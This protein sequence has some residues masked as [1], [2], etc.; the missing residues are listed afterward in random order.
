M[1]QQRAAQQRVGQQ[2]VGQWRLA[3]TGLPPAP[4]A[5][6]ARLLLAEALQAAPRLFQRLSMAAVAVWGAVAAAT[7]ATAAAAAA[8]AAVVAVVAVAA[9]AA[10]TR[11]QVRSS[12]PTTLLPPPS[13]HTGHSPH[14]LRRRW[15]WVAA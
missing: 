4:V 12:H 9:K 1:G 7:A 11:L 2:R 8:V 15:P 14:C 5:A 3:S 6:V 10:M 13:S